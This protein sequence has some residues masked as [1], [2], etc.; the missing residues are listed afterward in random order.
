MI[1]H[2]YKTYLNILDSLICVAV[3]YNFI[4]SLIG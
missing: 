4:K 2:V 3:V 1:L